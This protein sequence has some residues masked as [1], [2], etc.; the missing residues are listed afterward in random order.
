MCRDFGVRARHDVDRFGSLLK[1]P[2]DLSEVALPIVQVGADHVLAG[3]TDGH[4]VGRLVVGPVAQALPHRCRLGLADAPA[5]VDGVARVGH[6][7]DPI[8]EAAQELAIVVGEAG[9]EIERALRPDRPDRASG[10][11]QLAFEARI[12]VDRVV[13]FGRLAIDQ[14]GPQQDEVAEPRVDQVAVNPHVAE[15]GLD[16]HR[17]VGDDPDGMPRGL[18]HL[19]RESHRGVHRPD[20]ALLE[21]GHDGRADL[22]DLVAC[23][24]EFEV[25]HRP[26]RP[27]NGSRAMRS[28][29]L[30]SDLVQG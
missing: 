7:L 23:A 21:P 24:V 25:G 26:G 27:R 14:H 22:V 10:D 12:V 8:G 19:H 4:A 9:R 20:P 11:A 3:R 15:A 1:G 30:S 28:T 13:V 5:I 6:L 29:R 2:D 16:G 17:L 18:I